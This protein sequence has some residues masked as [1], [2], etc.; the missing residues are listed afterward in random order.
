MLAFTEKFEQYLNADPELGRRLEGFKFFSGT[1]DG[2]Y[3]RAR[4]E[5]ASAIA[6][7]VKCY[8]FGGESL[9]E[10]CELIGIRISDAKESNTFTISLN[11]RKFSIANRKWK[12]PHLTIELD[13]ELFKKT[14]LGRYRW[15][16]VLG[17]DEVKLAHSTELPHSDWVTLLEVLVAMQ[18]LLEFD[19]ELWEMVENY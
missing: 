19:K 3:K 9:L 2:H 18:E 7:A 10:D 15:L 14:L 17:M 5:G 11:D 16:W 4:Q 6:R 13:K 1:P 8:P 12:N